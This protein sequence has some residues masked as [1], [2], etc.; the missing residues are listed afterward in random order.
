MVALTLTE[1]LAQAEAAYHAL[2]SGKAVVEVSDQSGESVKYG[3][4]SARQ[5][6]LYCADLRRQIG[7]RPAPT[8]IVFRTSKGL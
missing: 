8:T 2:M 6:Q 1:R 4:A 3:Q 5:L 7:G